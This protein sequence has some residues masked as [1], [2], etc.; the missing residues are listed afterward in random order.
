MDLKLDQPRQPIGSLA[1][2]LR[3]F[4]SL[5]EFFTSAT[6][7]S[8]I[9]L[10]FVLLFIAAIFWIGGFWMVL[11]GADLDSNRRV[12]RTRPAARAARSHPA[13][14]CGDRSEIFDRHRDAR[15]DRAR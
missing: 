14:L 9:D 2:N 12:G 5:R 10:P 8:I 13:Q 4:E 11:P 3:E 1:N 7:A 6:L 15:C